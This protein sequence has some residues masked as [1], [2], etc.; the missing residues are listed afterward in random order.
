LSFPLRRGKEAEGCKRRS[1]DQLNWSLENPRSRARSLVV[2]WIKISIVWD[3]DEQLEPTPRE[4]IA[5]H[6]AYESN[7]IELDS[8]VEEKKL[9]KFS[10]PKRKTKKVTNVVALIES[11][12]MAIE[13]VKNSV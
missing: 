3:P 12:S 2:G 8:Y 4:T 11:Q 5:W 10:Q 13:L 7:P 6:I 9:A 1:L